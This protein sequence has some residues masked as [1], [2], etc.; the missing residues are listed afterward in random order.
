MPYH[1]FITGKK[2]DTD[3]SRLSWKNGY[4]WSGDV[5]IAPQASIDDDLF[6]YMYD[7]FRWLRAQYP[8][9]KW[10]DGPDPYAYSLIQHPEDIR[11]L[12]DIAVAWKRLFS[13]GPE[14]I[15]LTGNY[16]WNGDED[17]QDGFYE[18][19]YFSKKELVKQMDNL[20]AVTQKALDNGVYVIH[21]G[22]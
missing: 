2:E 6:N 7:A 12:Q 14:V 13:A 18:K 4:V 9:G 19:L 16:S 10:G 3:H 15:Q 22:I 20:I 11:R 1:Q 8:N 17:S 5:A 21:F